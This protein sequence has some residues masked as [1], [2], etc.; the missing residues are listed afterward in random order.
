MHTQ[1]C[2]IIEAAI[3]HLRGGDR[4]A[5]IM[6]GNNV[7]ALTAAGSEQS[8]SDGLSITAVDA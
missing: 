4:V 6:N 5:S 7:A 2:G 3:T 8:H 1:T